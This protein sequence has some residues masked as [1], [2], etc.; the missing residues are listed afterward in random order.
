MIPVQERLRYLMLY[1]LCF[2]VSQV[3]ITEMFP[4]YVQNMLLRRLLRKWR[5]FLF[6]VVKSIVSKEILSIFVPQKEEMDLLMKIQ[7]LSY[8]CRMVVFVQVLRMLLQKWRIFLGLTENSF[9][10]FLC[11]H[12]GIF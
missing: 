11:L 9:R 12:R 1:V 5:W 3:E 7:T 8:I 6:M 10:R 2:S 4:C